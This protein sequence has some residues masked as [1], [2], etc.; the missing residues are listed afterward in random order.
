MKEKSNAN[1]RQV[2][3]TRSWIFE[4]LMLLM[5]E[6]P[7]N[8]ISVSDIVEK[9]G[10]ARQ[11]FYRSYN[12][13]DDVILQ[14]FEGQFKPHLVKIENTFREGERSVMEMT[15]PLGQVIKHADIIKKILNSDAEHLGYAAARKNETIINDLYMGKV[16]KDIQIIF[17]YI[18]N[19]KNYGATRL[20]CDWIKDDMPVPVETIT[21]LIRQMAISFDM[22]EHTVYKTA[23]PHIVLNIQTEE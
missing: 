3:R 5:D 15:I 1:N 16:P 9:A 19:Y 18:V 13:K 17:N 7:Y 20:I 10:I 2:K 11:T 8:E 22:P 14:F 12:N 21:G 23:I 4:A 6:K